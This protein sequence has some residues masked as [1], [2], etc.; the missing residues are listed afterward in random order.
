MAN[1]KAI[2]LP[3]PL[4]APVTMHTFPVKEGS[5]D[6]ILSWTTDRKIGNRASAF[7]QGFFLFCFALLSSPFGLE[8][9]CHLNQT[10]ANLTPTGPCQNEYL[11]FGFMTKNTLLKKS[12]LASHFIELFHFIHDHEATSHRITNRLGWLWA[13]PWK[14]STYRGYTSWDLKLFHVLFIQVVKALLNKRSHSLKNLNMANKVQRSVK[15]IHFS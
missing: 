5:S 11:N 7:T 2:P 12:S 4:E 14:M 1:I 13:V 9:L 15:K 3:I 8:I 6:A 10:V